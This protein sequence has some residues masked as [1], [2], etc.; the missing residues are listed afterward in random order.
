LKGALRDGGLPSV[1]EAL[2]IPVKDGGFIKRGGG[3]PMG[4]GD[5][6][7]AFLNGVKKGEEDKKG[8]DRMQTD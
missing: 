4:G 7:E 1:S 3:V 5:A 8:D 6:V 2:R